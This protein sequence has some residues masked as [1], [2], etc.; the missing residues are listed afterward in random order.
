M[1]NKYLGVLVAVPALMLALSVQAHSEKEHMKTAESPDCAVMNTMDHSKMD[2]NDPVVMAMMQQCMN[3]MHN[4]STDADSSAHGHG[5]QMSGANKVG[6]HM[7]AP[8]Q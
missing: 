5:E 3:T 2:M 8:S 4:E 6:D 1:I 7:Q